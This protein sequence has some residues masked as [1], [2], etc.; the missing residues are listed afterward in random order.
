MK[1][2]KVVLY[3]IDT[4]VMGADEVRDLLADNK[5]LYPIVG[6]IET[7]DIG[8]WSDDHEL[9]KRGADFEKYFK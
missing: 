9:N 7:A 1:A 4:E 3:V 2:H 5:Y 6:S 8:L